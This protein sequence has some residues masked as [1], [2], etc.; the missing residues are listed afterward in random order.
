MEAQLLIHK[1]GIS[2]RVVYKIKLSEIAPMQQVA[3][4][5]EDK[6]EALPVFLLLL[7]HNS[8]YPVTMEN[9]SPK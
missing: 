6:K 8:L 4:T 7:C 1:M 3:S 9:E 2:H 5:W